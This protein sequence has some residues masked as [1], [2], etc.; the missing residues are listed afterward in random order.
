V[1]NPT[2]G[3]IIGSF[4]GGF[5]GN[6]IHAVDAANGRV[7]FLF[8]TGTQ[9][10]VAYD[11][12]TFLPI[13]F[14]NLPF[15]INGIPRDLVRW[16]TNGLAFRTDSRE[17]VLVETALV[18]ASVSVPS[19]TPTPSPTPLPSPPYIPTFVRRINQPA[20]NLVFSEATQSLYA[21]VPASAGANGNS[22]TKINPV[23]AA[24]G[25]SVFI[26]SE[27]NRMA[28][29]NDGQTI[30][31]HLNGAN[32]ARRFDVL[33]ETPGLQ[34]T[35]SALAPTDMDVVPG[36]PGSLALSNGGSGLGVSIY[37]DG[38]KR[39]NTADINPGVGPIEFGASASVLYGYNN[40]SSAFDLVKYLVDSSG[41]TIS[42]VTQ[43]LYTQGGTAMKFVNGVLY[44]GGG[45]VVDPEAKTWLGKFQF[46]APQI[47]AVDAAN[48]RVFYAAPAGGFTGGVTIRA[49]D[50]NTFLPVGTI[51]V[52][53]ILNTP[54]NLVR[55]G[56]NGLAF[57]ASPGPF[58][59]NEPSR[60]YLIE[61]KLVSDGGSIPVGLELE[62]DQFTQFEAETDLLI[63]VLRTG[64]DSGSV[65]VNYATSDGT[66]T[67]G[68]D[69]TATSGTLTFGPGELTKFITVHIKD[70]NLF[71]NGDETFNVTLSNP[72]N[73]AVL[74][75][76]AT[77]TVTI[78]DSDNKP[79]ILFSSNSVFIVP[80]GDSGTTNLNFRVVLTN[81]TVQ[82]V[83][84]NY[85]TN[86]V[87]ATAG[88]DYVAS[89]GTITIPAGTS[90]SPTIS[91]PINGDTIVEPHELFTISLSN[92]T[93]VSFS[94]SSVFAT[95]L[96]DDA[97][98]QLT[99]NAFSVNEGAGFALLNVTRVGD[100]SRTATVFYSTSDTAGLQSCTIANSKA[101]ERCDYGTS[102]GTL[103]FAVGETSQLVVIPV[104]DDVLVE[105]DETFTINLS[106]PTGALL[107]GANSATLTIVDNDAAPATQN[108]ID[109][110]TPFITQQY[111]DFLGRLPDPIG[112]A[113]WTDTL[114]NCPNGGFGEFDNP[115]CDRVHVSAGFF[116]SEEFQGRG[117]FAYKF[118]EVGF[119]RRPTYAEFVPDMAQVGGPQSPQS[120]VLSKAAYTD[121][122]V[123]RPEFKNRYD[124]L[125][126]S[127][128]VDALE[129]NA[130][131]TLTNKAALVA[132]LNANQKT[133]AQVLRE[134]VE[135]QSV[136][137]KFFIRAFVA[138]Q[139]FG[140]L[141]RDPD[142]IGYNNWIN[143]LTADPSNF[144]HMIFGFI[145]SD[146]YR[147]RFGP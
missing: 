43:N 115:D 102:V 2:T 24:V 73:S 17:L 44:T 26:G 29:S 139:Y 143:T 123:Q 147:H 28:I 74:V 56:V 140:Y 119:D 120:E 79:G 14:V 49:F 59:T 77:T 22:I 16:G 127:A 54:V 33:T 124:A 58:A 45:Q 129:I 110:V 41:V 21:S 142:T 137:D 133:R 20:N 67:A 71:E 90:L 13:G 64:D 117:Y 131:V 46:G 122:F 19:P 144:R 30:W 114:G 65:S 93:N 108:P 25:P 68:S 86:N 42:T 146:E 80:E 52:P 136:T 89:S 106:S 75:A 88:S 103:H 57:N 48:H 18:N 85:A 121:A 66:A 141:R 38:V 109:G 31:A 34:F 32:A 55:W 3:E 100:T 82:V 61:S 15:F 111:I 135:L 1:L 101:S 70:D 113:N 62:R 105:G 104:V 4:T 81:P 78:N 12:N 130:E 116:L 126:N 9:R 83:T 10:I 138:M 132:A 99:N 94:S 128:Y 53:N 91:I 40:G 60:V 125:S 36:S 63:K 5:T 27:P 134:I 11:I 39:P 72:T 35:T 69:Y 8:Y 6:E 51:T 23:T 107:G 97:T 87:S 145:Y 76:P 92:A 98:V 84:V 47:M 118:Y 50:S 7:Y 37:D 95:I 112:L 96:N